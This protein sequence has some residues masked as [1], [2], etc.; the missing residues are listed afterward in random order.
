MRKR[1]VTV[2]LT[3]VTRM[4]LSEL[5]DREVW[6]RLMRSELFQFDE[7]VERAKIVKPKE[8]ETKK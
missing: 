6:T 7:R 4:S 2:Q 3:I 1:R 8:E 5:R